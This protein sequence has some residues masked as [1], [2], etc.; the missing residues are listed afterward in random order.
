MLTIKNL[1]V[2]VGDKAVLNGIN[3]NVKAG[4]VHAIMGPNGA[5]KS[6]LSKVIAGHPLYK[7]TA[8]SIEYEINLK[9]RDLLKLEPQERAREGIFISFQYPLEIAGLA[10]KEFLRAA[11]NE[12]SKH[13][14]SEPLDAFEF[15]TILQEKIKHLGINPALLER[16]LNVDFS[17]GEKKQNEIIQ[18]AML[19]PRIVFLDETDSGLDIDA[20]KIVAAG[21]EKLRS[22]NNALVLITHYHRILEHV[23]PDYVHILKAGKL[24][25]TGNIK[26]AMDIE[27]NG[28]ELISA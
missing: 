26:L 16:E 9:T 19:N 21:I 14:G 10:N 2:T 1:H 12:L 13:H 28:Y 6:S 24:V 25:K 4:E 17:G 8:G 11:F 15:E 27:A 7:V 5:G 18:L 20:L 22:P 23:H 3:L